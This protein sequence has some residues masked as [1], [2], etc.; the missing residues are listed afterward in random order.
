MNFQKFLISSAIAAG[1]VGG[2]WGATSWTA[3][4]SSP[5]FEAPVS[6]ESVATT[7]Q[8]LF[9]LAP[10]NRSIANLPGI[11]GW[12]NLFMAAAH[13]ISGGTTGT[14]GPGQLTALSMA[15]PDP[16]M[17][18]VVRRT[19]PITGTYQL[20]ASRDSGVADTTVGVYDSQTTSRILPFSGGAFLESVGG[21]GAVGNMTIDATT[22]GTLLKSMTK[23]T[24]TLLV[25]AAVSLFFVRRRTMNSCR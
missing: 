6:H 22:L 3:Q 10:G 21:P 19:A 13:N 7:S 25:A 17:L 1:S 9:A 18:N 12:Q 16:F 14:P 15:T 11:K 20:N 8:T 5:N 4:A 2:A 23:P 24:S